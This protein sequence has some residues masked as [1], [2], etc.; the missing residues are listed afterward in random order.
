MVVD[1]DTQPLP[2]I[3]SEEPGYGQENGDVPWIWEPNVPEDY[4]GDVELW[5]RIRG[6]DI[7]G[8]LPDVI[9]PYYI[10]ADGLQSHDPRGFFLIGTYTTKSTYIT[11]MP[12]I[13]R[14][15]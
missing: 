14:G 6:L 10:D 2:F 12:F 5:Q 8:N 3:S 11:Y 7:D 9:V 4:L 1:E 15:N 13:M